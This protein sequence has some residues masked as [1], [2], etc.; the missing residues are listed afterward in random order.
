MSRIT[1]YCKA[2]FNGLECHANDNFQLCDREYDDMMFKIYGH[3]YE[4]W[5][6]GETV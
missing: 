1:T 6:R 4:A 2:L 5:L 3:E